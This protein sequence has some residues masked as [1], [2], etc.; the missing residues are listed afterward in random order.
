MARELGAGLGNR[1]PMTIVAP[2]MQVHVHIGGA[3]G[4]R[5]A[6]SESNSEQS[7]D[8]QSE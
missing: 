1:Q 6:C 4:K 3:K 7:E 2:H 5:K 8:D